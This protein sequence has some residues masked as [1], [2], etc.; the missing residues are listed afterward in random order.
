MRT[1]IRILAALPVGLVL[2]LSSRQWMHSQQPA[3]GAEPVPDT[4]VAV[5][6]MFGVRARQP[7]SWDGELAAPGLKILRTT[8]VHFEDTDAILG[9]GRWRCSTR[10]TRYG[11]SRTP[12]G[13]DPVHTQLSQLVPNGVAVVLDGPASSRIEVITQGGSFGFR[14]EELVLGQPLSFL[15]GEATAE[16]LPPTIEWTREPG[17]N[18]YPALTVTRGGELWASWIRYQNRA[19]SVWAAP[20]GGVPEPVTTPGYS[21][22][23]RTA[24]A[25]DGG[26]R[27]WVVWSS[28]GTGR[29][30]LYGRFRENGRWSEIERL[31][32]SEGP[33]LYHALTADAKGRLH[34]VWQGFRQGRS[35]I[36]HQVWD[37]SRWSG[38]TL[39]SQAPADSWV[40]AVAADAK[41]N[42]WAAWDSYEAGNFDVYVRK[43]GSGGAPIR[44]TRSAG[45][46]ANVSL[47]A[48]AAGRLW[49]SWDAGDPNWGKDWTSMGW[50]PGGGNGLYRRREVRIACLEGDQLRAPVADLRSAIPAEYADYYQM[51]RLIPD[52]QGRVWA[53]VRTLTSFTTRVRNNWGAGGRWEMLV[54]RLEGDRWMPAVRLEGAAGR[55]DVRAAAAATPDGSLWFAWAGDRRP[56]RP[57]NPQKTDVFYTR[58]RPGGSGAAI[59][60]GPLQEPALSEPAVHPGEQAEV[61]A[62]RRYRYRIGAKTYR[63]LRGDLHRHT[64]I[65]QDGIGD[66][67]LLD[68]YRY[69]LNAAQLDYIL[70]ADHN[71]GGTEYNWWRTEKSEET[72]YVPGRFQPLFGTERSV[73]YPNG[74]RN[75]IF[76]RRGVRELAISPEEREG[77][78]STGAI[79][80]PYLRKFEGITT[81]HTPATDQ[82]TD[83][84]D[85]DPDLE[86]LVE[87]YQGLHTN[88]EYEGAPRAETEQQRYYFHGGP[89]R[90]AGFVWNA[91]AKGYKLGVQASSDHIATHDSYACVLVEEQEEGGR[92]GILR[93]MKQRHAYAATDNIILDVR[94]GGRLMGDIL[95]TRE[96]PPLEVR[97]IGTGPIDRVEVIRNNRF[98]HTERPGRPAAAFTFRDNEAPAGESY[99]YVRVS[100]ANGQM[101]WSSPIWVRR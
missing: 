7:G 82:G 79:L 32:G 80:Y 46:D 61:D 92:E 89:W 31:T 47:A 30:G 95:E 94:L 84:R 27:L 100:Q 19:D 72:F 52:A 64:D 17:E 85:N 81:L 25:E 33:N 83:W 68:L 60:M 4:A 20:A 10:R 24:L 71:Y 76:A 41:G 40:P 59:R 5:R 26:G 57:P 45:F 2:L 65:S 16:R 15:D 74:H 88:Y 63:I 91:W 96:T 37:G 69:A 54:T 23:F 38:E 35:Q 36:L 43:I 12:R 99:Y 66:G 98:V 93:A 77:K 55:N 48:D 56:F 34:L 6:L 87:L 78:L 90:P 86:P 9:P 44:V 50:K 58:L 70:V 73:P 22:N 3:V 21:D 8:G 42:V 49:I 13:P 101:A 75:T 11:D 62:I 28:K 1:S 14:L 39:V 51:A 53:M 97:V 18:D 67:S 29:W